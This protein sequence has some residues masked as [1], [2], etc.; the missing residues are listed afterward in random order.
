M[1]AL[2]ISFVPPAYPEQA[3]ASKLSGG[4]VLRV[5]VGK[6]GTV[7]NAQVIS[8]TDHVF[9]PTSLD[10]VKQWRYRP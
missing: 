8:A 5:L 2:R 10:A 3:R 9:D 6:N 7:E 1:Q 4:V